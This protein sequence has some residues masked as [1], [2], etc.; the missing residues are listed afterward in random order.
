MKEQTIPLGFLF[1]TRNTNVILVKII[2]NK[3]RSYPGM[4]AAKF[5]FYLTAPCPGA[6]YVLNE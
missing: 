2:D 1:F 6:P 5:I 4:C 3:L